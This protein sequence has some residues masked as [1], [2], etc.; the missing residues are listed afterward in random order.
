MEKAN[1][2]PRFDVWVTGLPDE[3][4]LEDAVFDVKMMRRSRENGSDTLLFPVPAKLKVV[5]VTPRRRSGTK[6]PGSTHRELAVEVELVEDAQKGNLNH[7]DDGQGLSAFKAG[8]R[9]VLVY[10]PSDRMARVSRSCEVL[11]VGPEAA[12]EA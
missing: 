6:V 4:Y 8:T 2:M 7:F 1:G 10:W 9:F 3:N 11:C 12:I 5:G